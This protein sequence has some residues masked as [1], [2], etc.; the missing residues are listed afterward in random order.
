MYSGKYLNDNL[1]HE[2]INLFKSDDQID[3]DG[4]KYQ[5]F[6]YLNPYGNFNSSYKGR[7][8][9]ML[10]VISVP[11]KNMFEVV[12][13]ATDLVDIFTPVPGFNPKLDDE[14]TPQQQNAEEIVRSSQ[15]DKIK[16]LTYGGKSLLELFDKDKQQAIFVT[17]AAKSVCRPK[18]RLF[19]LSFAVFCTNNS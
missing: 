14:K 5:N 15:E 7:I 11:K 17:F 13:K 16:G 9:D 1:G 8:K 10:M 6:I 3:I 4:Q 2:I 19:I 12:G 18:K